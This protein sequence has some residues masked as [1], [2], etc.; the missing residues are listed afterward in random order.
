MSLLKHLDVD[1]AR[2]NTAAKIIEKL[3]AFVD[4]TDEIGIE[5]LTYTML[6]IV[7]KI[8]KANEFNNDF[9]SIFELACLKA[10][11]F[12]L[13]VSFSQNL[14]QLSGEKKMRDLVETVLK[15]FF[16]NP[17]WVTEVCTLGRAD[18]TIVTKIFKFRSLATNYLQG[19]PYYFID[20][21]YFNQIFQNL[22]KLDAEFQS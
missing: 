20:S 10:S 16:E 21:V 1:L 12:D 18:D 9:G 4:S 3:G 5:V 22:P 14:S 8:V 11:S 7:P 6:K 15:T 13:L 19:C 17:L 2:C